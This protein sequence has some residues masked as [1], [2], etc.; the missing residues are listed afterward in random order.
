MVPTQWGLEPQ[1]PPLTH[2]H[3]KDYAITIDKEKADNVEKL[4]KEKADNEEKLSKEKAEELEKLIRMMEATILGI[5]DPEKQIRVP[6]EKSGCRLPE[7]TDAGHE[8]E[9]R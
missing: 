1:N 8:D 7:G 6:G 4:A 2:Q 5:G 3:Y 9:T